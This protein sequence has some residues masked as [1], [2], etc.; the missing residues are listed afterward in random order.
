MYK[1]P[2]SPAG[3]VG[4]LYPADPISQESYWESLDWYNGEMVRDDY[5]LGCCLYQVGESGQWI[6]F[7]HLGQDNSQQP[8]TIIPRVAALNQAPPPP[9]PPPP[10]ATG[11]LPTLQ[12]RIRQ[13]IVTLEAAVRQL[14]DYVSLVNRLQTD[15][16]GLAAVGTQATTLPQSLDRLQARLTQLT[17][18]VNALATQGQISA[19]Q[20]TTLRQRIADLSSRVAA[21]RPAAEQAA[22]LDAQVRQAQSQ[23]PPLNDGV[24]RPS[25]CSRRSTRSWPKPGDWPCRRE[26]RPP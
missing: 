5:A 6:T 13:L 3:D 18:Q 26:S 21:L 4:W 22:R 1:Y 14:A 9:P 20:A 17:A 11:D 2:D 10:P 24:R 19:A 25:A 23:M 8:L 7:R 12:R 16:N 15:L